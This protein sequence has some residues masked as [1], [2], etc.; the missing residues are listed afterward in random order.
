MAR[1]T[2]ETHTGRTSHHPQADLVLEPDPELLQT[3]ARKVW[4]PHYGYGILVGYAGSPP[5]IAHAAR[6][7]DSTRA[8]VFLQHCSAF[9]I[10]N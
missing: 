2:G 8:G 3:I 9:F 5:A 4:S 7:P 10:L 6:Y 1:P